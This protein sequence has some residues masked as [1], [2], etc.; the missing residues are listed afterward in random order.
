M[1]KSTVKNAAAV[2]YLAIGVLCLL[3]IGFSTQ[4][5][6]C[7]NR[8]PHIMM[9]QPWLTVT[10]GNITQNN[11][12]YNASVTILCSS[13]N[14]LQKLVVSPAINSSDGIANSSNITSTDLKVYLNGTIENPN[15]LN[16]KFKS[17]DN[18]QV[19]FIIPSANDTSGTLMG[20]AIT[21]ERHT[22]ATSPSSRC[23]EPFFI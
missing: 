2:V 12:N 14:Q 6:A 17:G 18:I 8:A 20:I 3:C 11:D 22:Q 15:E 4:I 9:P 23:L 21:A 10:I 13:A 5:S 7:T 16:Y 19:N 1:K